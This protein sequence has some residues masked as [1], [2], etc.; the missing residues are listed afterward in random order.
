MTPSFNDLGSMAPGDGS[1]SDRRSS[2][3]TLSQDE[4]DI[5]RIMP[6]STAVGLAEAQ[7]CRLFREVRSLRCAA[8]LLALFEC[9]KVIPR[10]IRGRVKWVESR[11]DPL[12]RPKRRRDR[13]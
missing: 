8:E 7:L 10:V 3:A 6:A 2:E 9:G 13:R 11:H 5:L 12:L 1:T 4:I